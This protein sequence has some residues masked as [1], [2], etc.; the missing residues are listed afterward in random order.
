MQVVFSPPP[1]QKRKSVEQNVTPSSPKKVKLS[2]EPQLK[3]S[4]SVPWFDSSIG[5]LAVGDD[6]QGGEW[7]EVAEGKMFVRM[8][9]E[10]AGGEK[11]AVELLFNLPVKTDSMSFSSY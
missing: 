2:T 5:R 9:K 1:A 6:G 3:A 8:L 11:I 7:R 4:V 10:D